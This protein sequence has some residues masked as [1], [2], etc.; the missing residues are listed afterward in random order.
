MDYIKIFDSI[1]K[2]NQENKYL[3]FSLSDQL[4]AFPASAIVQIIELKKISQVP[5][6]PEYVTGITEYSGEIVPVID[7]KKV[8]GYEERER[9][10]RRV[11]IVTQLE[12]KK[13]AFMV[14]SADF[15]ENVD[16][17][18]I[19]S[20]DMLKNFAEKEFINSVLKIRE[21]IVLALDLG[22]LLDF[23]FLSRMMEV[24][25]NNNTRTQ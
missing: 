11:A 6:V 19:E 4:F 24:I 20:A 15:L 7:L 18:S 14:D 1:V 22:K 9:K 2:G 10:S 25:E 3:V 21:K 17:K 5:E 23:D 12:R 8:F 16:K 13:C